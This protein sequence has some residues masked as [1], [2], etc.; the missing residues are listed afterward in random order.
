M[1][2]RLWAVVFLRVAIHS[3]LLEFRSSRDASASLLFLWTRRWIYHF[4][5]FGF[6]NEVELGWLLSLLYLQQMLPYISLMDYGLNFLSIGTFTT[7]VFL[8]WVYGSQ[9]F[10]H[11]LRFIALPLA[12]V[13]CLHS[14]RFHLIFTSISYHTLIHSFHPWI[15]KQ[16]IPLPQSP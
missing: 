15:V 3:Q 10:I 16:L 1:R 14:L 13:C 5:A 8:D 4:F 2:V 9:C 6:P 11:H 7:S 12:L